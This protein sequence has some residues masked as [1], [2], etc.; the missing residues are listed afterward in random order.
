MEKGSW[1]KSCLIHSEHTMT[2]IAIDEVLSQLDDTTK[3]SLLAGVDM[4]HTK[5]LPEFGVPPMRMSD[6]RKFS[7][8][9]NNFVS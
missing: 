3:I 7:L 8:G 6:G 9:V 4:W 5:A 1:C 2:P